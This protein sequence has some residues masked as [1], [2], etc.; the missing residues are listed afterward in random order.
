MQISS[1][2][3]LTDSNNPTHPKLKTSHFS[4][5]YSEVWQCVSTRDSRSS[6]PEETFERSS[7]RSRSD[8]GSRG[9]GGGGGGRRVVRCRLGGLTGLR[10]DAYGYIAY[11]VSD[12]ESLRGRKC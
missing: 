4:R 2:R 3:N 1:C 11:R 10:S 8:L 5:K 12:E 7:E 9:R 6:D